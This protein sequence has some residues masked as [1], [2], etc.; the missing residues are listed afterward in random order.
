[1]EICGIPFI[2]SNGRTRGTGRTGRP[3]GRNG[4]SSGRSI[5]IDGNQWTLWRTAGWLGIINRI[6]H[7]FV[8]EFIPSW[9]TAVFWVSHLGLLM[10]TELRRIEFLFC[11][12]FLPLQRDIFDPTT[13]CQEKQKKRRSIDEIVGLF[14]IFL[15]GQFEIRPRFFDSNNGYPIYCK[16]VLI[17]P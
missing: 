13:V 15:C 9:G 16:F 6:S 1:M 17:N 7:F 12:S 8:G 4:S 11:V 3:T 5:I 14:N 2:R 10:T